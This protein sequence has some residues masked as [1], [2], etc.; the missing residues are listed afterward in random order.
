M[1]PYTPGVYGRQE[2]VGK[3]GKKNEILVVAPEV[4]ARDRSSGELRFYTILKILSARYHIV[5]VALNPR[6]D[7]RDGQYRPDIEALGLEVYIQNYSF[8]KIL[9]TH[10]FSAALIEFYLTAEHCLSNIRVLQ[11]RCPIIVDSVDVHYY[12]EWLK[13][14]L[15]GAPEDL[16]K[17][18]E[19]R[20]D[21]MTK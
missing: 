1:S 20:I 12:R 10:K 3:M 2:D 21:F 15:T 19:T 8:R 5:F 11:P 17:S 16:T 13:Y 4:P 18:L 14:K 7:Q 9:S 6:G